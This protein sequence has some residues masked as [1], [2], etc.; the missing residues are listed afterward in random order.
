M[1]KPV[2]SNADGT[3]IVEHSATGEAEIYV[4]GTMVGK[5]DTPGS[6]TIEIK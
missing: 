1:S 6:T 5:M 2:Y 3:A 4:N